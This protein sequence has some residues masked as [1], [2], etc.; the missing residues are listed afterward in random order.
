MTRF[1]SVGFSKST[2]GK[3]VFFA[4][5][6]LFPGVLILLAGIT[7][8][9]QAKKLARAPENQ[10]S[11]HWVVPKPPSFFSGKP[12]LWVSLQ[13]HLGE[14]LIENN[15]STSLRLFS[16]GKPLVLRDSRGL[17]HRAQSITLGWRNEPLLKSKKLFRYVV[18]PFGSF[19]S[20]E[21]L[22]I[23][24]RTEG[25]DALVAHPKDWEVWLPY[26]TRIPK[27]LSTVRW[28]KN[29]SA[30]LEP[31]LR[32]KTGSRKLFGPLEL[33]APDGLNWQGGVYKGP[34]RLQQD[35]YGTWTLLELVPM[36]RYLEGVVSHEIGNFVPVSALQAQTVL[37]RTWAMANSHRFEVDGYHLCS[38]T[39]CQVYKDPTK[40]NQAVKDAIKVTSGRILSWQAKP[41]HAVYHASNGGV[42]AAGNEAWAMKSVPYLETKLDGPKTWTNR[43]EMPLLKRS[44]VLSFLQDGSTAYGS[45]HTRFRWVRVITAEQLQQAISS[46][47]M[48]NRLKVTERGPSGR[49]LTLEIIGLRERSL[50][51]LRL[52]EIRRYL[53]Q[54]PSTLFVVDEVGPGVWRFLGGGFGHGAGLSQAGAIDLADR[55]WTAQQI[56]MHYYPSTIYGPLLHSV[57]A[58]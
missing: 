22:A 49:V 37:A 47:E 16:A 57:I 2:R 45:Q 52:D 21:R 27:G 25:I 17:V 51:E 48:P 33:E 46:S 10:L 29:I 14:N 13:T 8:A 50:V 5:A 35:A 32:L 53:P 55:G 18:G 58:P 24:L 6:A 38:D 9:C 15:L 54:L 39:Q 12:V 4:S 56:L 3:K 34:F 11:T 44:K 23:R 30:V 36:H 26:G 31:V 19:E 1:L 40:A 41:I 7:S 28:R 20:A 43:F 42:M